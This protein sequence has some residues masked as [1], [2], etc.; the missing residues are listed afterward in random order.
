MTVFLG[1]K[2]KI[3]CDFLGNPTPKVTW[4]RSPA[5]PLP[6]GRSEVKKDGLY[7]NHTEREDGGVYTCLARNDYGIKLHGTFLKVRSVG[8]YR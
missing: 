6:Q 1:K 5:K 2:A 4:A 8:R 7:I 3:Q